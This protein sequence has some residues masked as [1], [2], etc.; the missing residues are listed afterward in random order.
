MKGREIHDNC[1]LNV[2]WGKGVTQMTGVF[3]T[4]GDRGGLHRLIVLSL[5]SSL[6]II[7]CSCSVG[8]EPPTE[9]TL[10]YQVMSNAQLL[11]VR[12]DSPAVATP[13]VGRPDWTAQAGQFRLYVNHDHQAGDTVPRIDILDK[14]G[15]WPFTMLYAHDTLYL[16]ILPAGCTLSERSSIEHLPP[17]F[18]LVVYAGVQ[19]ALYRFSYIRGR[20]TL[21]P[22][23][24][25]DFLTTALVHPLPD[26]TVFLQ[27]PPSNS[28]AGLI[29]G[30][31]ADVGERAELIQLDAGFY[32]SVWYYVKK[33]AIRRWKVNETADGVILFFRPKYS[34]A[35]LTVRDILA[36]YQKRGH[37]D[38]T[39]KQR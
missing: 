36:N 9:D 4:S 3:E 2:E 11:D 20:T 7:I 31:V 18:P 24:P 27:L 8:S 30:I 35:F 6:A 37:A 12:I 15:S 14:S 23:A 34:D 16:H 32:Q 21:D 13:P 25:A 19:R 17:E 38:A 28:N 5:L 39:D 1:W 22:L 29:A 26:N 10:R 33:T